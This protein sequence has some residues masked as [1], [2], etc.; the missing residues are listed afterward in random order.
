MAKTERNLSSQFVPCIVCGAMV[1]VCHS[2]DKRFTEEQEQA[3]ARW[4]ES[5]HL[6]EE[7]RDGGCLAFFGKS[8]QQFGTRLIGKIWRIGHAT[9]GRTRPQAA[10]K[11]IVNIIQGQIQFGAPY[12]RRGPTKEPKQFSTAPSKL[13][14]TCTRKRL[15]STIE[16]L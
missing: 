3:E 12:V 14:S 7:Y 5:E 4:G 9:S 6:V 16:M 11:F 15:D 2:I 10:W 1:C 13:C 8:R